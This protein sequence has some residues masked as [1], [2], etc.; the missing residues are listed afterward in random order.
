MRPVLKVLTAL[1]SIIAVLY[2]TICLYFYFSQDEMI[3]PATKLEANYKFSFDQPFKEYNIKNVNDTLSGV[4]FKADKPKGLIFYLHG[5][6]GT[7]EDWSVIA[8]LYNGKTPY[9]KLQYDLFILDYPG[10]G[11]STGNVHNEDELLRSIQ[12]AF[13][14]IKANYNQQ[15]VIIM[16]YSIGTGLATWL[17]S[18]NNCSKLVLFAPYYSLP[19]L[20]ATLYP[21]LPS[22]LILKYKLETY[23]YLPQVKA[24]ITIFHGNADKLIYYGSSVKLKSQF[25]VNDRLII[26]DGQGHNH[27]QENK[28]FLKEIENTLR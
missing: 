2:L 11:K 13:D 20:V 9:N 28:I 5:N 24:P 16:G 19:D 7:V 15:P 6:G 14:T 10:Y 4:L 25:K 1:L 21:Y 17:A 22:S 3:F 8:P 27:I 12:T 23:K 18:K 26:L